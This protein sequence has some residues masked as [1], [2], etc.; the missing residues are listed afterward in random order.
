M[1]LLALRV[2]SFYV[3]RPLDEVGVLREELGEGPDARIDE[4]NVP[5]YPLAEVFGIGLDGEAG[6]KALDQ[7][8]EHEE[9]VG[10]VCFLWHVSLSSQKNG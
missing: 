8:G 6:F 10:V 5:S 1:K 9:I 2:R 4:E 7:G 3:L